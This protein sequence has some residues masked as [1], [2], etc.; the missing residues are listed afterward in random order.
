[1][2]VS[3]PI[4]FHYQK[5]CTST[6]DVAK[7]LIPNY[8]K[9]IILVRSDEQT[10]GKG[11][12]GNGWVSKLNGGLYVTIHYPNLRIAGMDAHLIN[13]VTCLS[14][15]EV[16]GDIGI[17]D[18]QF[19]WPN[20]LYTSK[21]KIGGLLTFNQHSKGSILASSIGIGINFSPV[22][23]VANHLGVSSVEEETGKSDF[24]F[25]SI[26]V[27][28]CKTIAAYLYRPLV[29]LNE[30][31][32]QYKEL[33]YGIDRLFHVQMEDGQVGDAKIIGPQMDGSLLIEWDNE[34]KK[35]HTGAMKWLYEV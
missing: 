6:F 30:I 35:I 19:K 14:C 15:A 34:Q 3:P 11:Q 12:R 9:H 2:Q 27:Q 4:H 26:A 28:L 10:K 31:F 23:S 22:E 33:N 17:Q 16:L 18:V 20:D 24:D 32:N 5:T 21:G 29:N 1:M 8:P 7:E 25:N 13:W